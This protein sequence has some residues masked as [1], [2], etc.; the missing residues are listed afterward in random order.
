MA[1]KCCVTIVLQFLAILLAK[2]LIFCVYLA[3]GKKNNNLDAE[4]LVVIR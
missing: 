3:I 1:A 2:L 4:N